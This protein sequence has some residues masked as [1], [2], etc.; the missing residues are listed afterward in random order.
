[1]RIATH[2]HAHAHAHTQT[3]THAHAHTQAQ[4]QAQ[5]HAQAHTHAHTH[6]LAHAHCGTRQSQ[7]LTLPPP[8]SN[9][10][11]SCHT[12][13]CVVSQMTWRCFAAVIGRIESWY[14]SSDFKPVVRTVPIA[15]TT[16]ATSTVTCFQRSGAH[17]R[18]PL[19]ARKLGCAL[20]GRSV[21]IFEAANAPSAALA[22]L[23]LATLSAIRARVHGNTSESSET[24]G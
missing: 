16:P 7:V 9:M 11:E 18:C 14:G 15:P 1:M 4:A 19:E 10:N 3:H 5:A 8:S 24:P 22:T 13:E 20:K 6:A 12:H 21:F 2:T 17:I 23:S